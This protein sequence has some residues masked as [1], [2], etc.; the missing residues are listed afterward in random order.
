MPDRELL[1]VPLGDRVDKLPL[2][3][4][5]RIARGVGIEPDE[6]HADDLAERHAGHDPAIR[7]ATLVVGKVVADVR[8]GRAAEHATGRAGEGTDDEE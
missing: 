7:P 4:A 3:F 6:D 2:P 8:D 1:F 5:F